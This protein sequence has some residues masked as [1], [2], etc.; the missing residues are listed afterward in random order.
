MIYIIDQKK[1]RK[2]E[3]EKPLTIIFDYKQECI[4]YIYQ[5]INQSINLNFNTFTLEKTNRFLLFK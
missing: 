4:S 3:E 1:R 2:K 5:R